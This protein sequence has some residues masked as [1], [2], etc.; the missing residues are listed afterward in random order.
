VDSVEQASDPLATF[1][2]DSLYTPW[3]SNRVPLESEWRKSWEGF[4]G[5]VTGHWKAAEGTSYRSNRNINV[6]RQ[7]CMAAYAMIVTQV[8]RGG[9]L[10]CTVKPAQPDAMTAA[11]L[12]PDAGELLAQQAKDVQAEVDSVLTACDAERVYARNILAAAVYGESYAK[13]TVLTLQE[14]RWVPAIP[15]ELA[16]DVAGLAPEDVPWT[17]TTEERDTWGWAYVPVWE[18][19]R[20]L[21][22]DDMQHNAGFFHVRR[23]SPFW[24]NGLRGK[25]GVRDDVVLR[26]IRDALRAG[27]KATPRSPMA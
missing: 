12:G 16:G 18:I 6:I 4:R 23:V 10:A 2:S 17:M 19:V 7:K 13:E 8:I 14:P 1:L 24:L 26:V 15:P 5:I 22:S 9:R 27:A 21:E 11:M 20:D 25:P 3:K